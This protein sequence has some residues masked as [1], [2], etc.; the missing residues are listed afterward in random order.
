MPAGYVIGKK[1]FQVNHTMFPS[2]SIQDLLT[3]LEAN[4][5][6]FWNFSR[7]ISKLYVQLFAKLFISLLYMKM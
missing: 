3:V 5:C 7:I 6:L 2:R 1:V 4:P